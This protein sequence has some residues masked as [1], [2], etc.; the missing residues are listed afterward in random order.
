MHIKLLF[1][2]AVLA[3]ALLGGAIPLLG[4]RSARAG[5]L[6]GWGNGFAAGVFLGAGLIHLL[7]D[8]LAAGAQLGW[9]ATGISSTWRKMGRTQPVIIARCST[10]CA[11]TGSAH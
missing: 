11:W 1:S 10:R 7:P 9:E 8:A 3:A 4:R 5:R 6:L 2:L